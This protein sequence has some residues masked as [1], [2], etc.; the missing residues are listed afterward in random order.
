MAST[1]LA[2]LASVSGSWESGSSSSVIDGSES[3]YVS[4]SQSGDGATEDLTV[5]LD[6]AS[7]LPWVTSVVLKYTLYWGGSSDRYGGYINAWLKQ[8]DSWLSQTHTWDTIGGDVREWSYWPPS[9]SDST[10]ST[11]TLTGTWRNLQGV[12]FYLYG[13]IG[14]HTSGVDIKVYE[15]YVYGPNY[16][17]AGLRIYDGTS[18]KTLYVEDSSE[19]ALRIRKGSTNYGIPLIDTSRA[20]ASPLRIRKGGV[21]YATPWNG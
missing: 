18:T 3:S 2:N 10:K 13:R 7:A 1:N 16:T 8:G 11:I 19:H 17:D 20:D 5:Q 12:K 14:G 6:F 4:A 21:T 9:G 15:I